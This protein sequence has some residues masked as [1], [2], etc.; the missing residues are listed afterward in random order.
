MTA[1][2]SQEARRAALDRVDEVQRQG[3]L[4][5]DAARALREELHDALIAEEIRTICEDHLAPD[6]ESP[7]WG[8]PGMDR[9]VRI[10]GVQEAL[11][12]IYGPATAGGVA[13][14]AD[15]T[16]RRARRRF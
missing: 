1:G 9:Q 3:D 12:E 10:K 5:G 14:Q 4:E 15:E 6:K 2:E 16:Y 8:D 7:D 11:E 13:E